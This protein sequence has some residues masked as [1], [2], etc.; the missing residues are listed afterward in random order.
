[1]ALNLP[2]NQ[3]LYLIF[4]DGHS[5]KVID[6]LTTSNL[7]EPLI[8]GNTYFRTTDGFYKLEVN[9]VSIS[10]PF[11]IHTEDRWYKLN[12]ESDSYEPIKGVTYEIKEK[13]ND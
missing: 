5:E 3:E 7:S 12:T 11:K 1:M 4:E 9:A 6:G 13:Q 8:L 2:P 10:M